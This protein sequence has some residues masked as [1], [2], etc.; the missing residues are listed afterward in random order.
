MVGLFKYLYYRVYWWDNRIVKNNSYPI[1]STVLGIS[2]FHVLNIKFLSD[3]FLYI[4]L[5][6]RDLIVNQDKVYGFVVVFFIISINWIYFKRIHPV[7][8]AKMEQLDKKQKRIWDIVIILYMLITL[9]TTIGLAYI[10]R[11]NY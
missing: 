10:I 6:R 9:A 11:N 3:F 5:N 4:I 1:F 8:L 7:V 2:F